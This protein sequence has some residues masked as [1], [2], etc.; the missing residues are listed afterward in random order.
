MTVLLTGLDIGQMIGAGHYGTVYRAIDPVH[1]PVAAKVMRRLDAE[2]DCEWQRRRDGLLQEAQRLATATHR[3]VVQVYGCMADP[4]GE[5]ICFTMKLCPRGSLQ[6]AFDQ[7]PMKLSNVRKVA[8]EVTFGLQALHQRGMLH[9]DIKPANILLD[10]DGVAL[11]GDFGWVTDEIFMGYARAGGYLDHLAYE[12]WTTGRASVKTDIWA[13]GMTLYRLLHGKNW[14][15][16]QGTPRFEIGNGGF[17]NSLDWLPHIPSR[18]RR[19]VRKMMADNPPDRYQNCEQLLAAFAGLPVE[20][21]WGCFV[22]DDL[23]AWSRQQRARLQKVEWTR[24]S[25]RKHAWRAWSEPVDQGRRKTLGTSEGPVS[26]SAC[27]KGL[28]GFFDLT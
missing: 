26:R 11:L 19:V 24:Y 25:E 12:A 2:L 22:D 14:Y 20:A 3:N 7:G 10:H 1:G 5:S 8:T 4:G 9:R 15:A 28:K 13:L 21:D 18:W 23:I 16:R 17:V 27:V 6:N